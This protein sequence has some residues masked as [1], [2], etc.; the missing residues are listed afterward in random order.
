MKK[1]LLPLLFAFLFVLS[2]GLQAQNLGRIIRKTVIQPS[3]TAN[4]IAQ[5]KAEEEAEKQLTKAIMEGFGVEENARFGPDYPFTSWFNMQ[6]TNYNKN[7]NVDEVVVYDNYLNASTN[8]YGMVFMDDDAQSTII[9]DSDRYAMIILADNKGEKSGFATKF[10]PDMI[11]EAAEDA[12]QETG[13]FN[14]LKTGNTKKIL[15]YNC[16][17]YKVDD[18]ESE[19]HIWVSEKLGKELHKKMLSNSTAFGAAFQY[20]SGVEGMVME[21]K[22][23]NKSSKEKTEM[24]IT[25]LDLKKSHRISTEGYEILSIN[26]DQEDS[27]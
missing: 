15:G 2:S 11:E 26:L 18:E 22:V 3:Q 16:D 8:D 1:T 12:E 14:L 25:D 6:I 5:D 7:G 10:D 24:L 19:V 21:Y 9:F 13:D 20:A 4:D 23:L 17:E 27:Q